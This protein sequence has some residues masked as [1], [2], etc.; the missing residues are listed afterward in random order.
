MAVL[1]LVALVA[2]IVPLVVSDLRTRTLNNRLVLLFTAVVALAPF[3]HTPE[4]AGLALALWSVGA[5]LVAFGL[6][7][8]AYRTGSIGAGDVKLAFGIV[9]VETWFGSTAWLVYLGCAI[10]AI[11]VTLWLLLRLRRTAENPNVPLGPALLVGVIPSL[12][13]VL[14]AG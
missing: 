2:V 4:G 12:A 10:V 14:F 5:G 6:G 11:A 9:A 3:V 1:W 7:S 8:A 13:A